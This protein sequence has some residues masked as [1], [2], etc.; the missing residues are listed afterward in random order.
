MNPFGD[1]YVPP[2]VTTRIFAHGG[3]KCKGRQLNGEKNRSS[4]SWRIEMTIG[5]VSVEI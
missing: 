1:G 2:I 4:A 3:R 5:G